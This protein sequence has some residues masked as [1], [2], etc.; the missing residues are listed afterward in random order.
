VEE[1]IKTMI[2]GQVTTT[3]LLLFMITCLLK[4]WVVPFWQ[5]KEMKDKLTAYEKKAPDLISE[6]Q[7]LVEIQKEENARL[8]KE[9]EDYDLFERTRPSV[10]NKNT[11]PPRRG[12][13][14]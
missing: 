5:I 9:R 6:V 2:N 14:Q 11:R 4:G 3:G 8:A 13:D 7:K 1:L 10:R 12:E